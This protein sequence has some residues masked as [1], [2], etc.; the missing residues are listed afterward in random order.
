VSDGVLLSEGNNNIYDVNRFPRALSGILS[1]SRLNLLRKTRFLK[2][3]W[4]RCYLVR[5]R[6]RR[7]LSTW[8]L[9]LLEEGSYVHP[10]YYL[11][12]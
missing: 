9:T 6:N 3:T 1:A 12:S 4:K 8:S 5:M 10:G 2:T 7:S 11:H